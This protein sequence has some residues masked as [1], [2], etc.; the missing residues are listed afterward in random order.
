MSHPHWIATVTHQW[1]GTQ[2]PLIY[3]V[4]PSSHEYCGS[5]KTPVL[6]WGKHFHF[7]ILHPLP[8]RK[9][10]T[11]VTFSEI[12]FSTVST[13][14]S[15]KPLRNTKVLYP[16]MIALELPDYNKIP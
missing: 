13:I 3:E 12:N 10:K 2:S 14:T 16:C 9:Q 6:H 1:K 4:I 8:I 5:P 11:S 7:H 15:Y